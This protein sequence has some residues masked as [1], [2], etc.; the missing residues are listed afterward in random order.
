MSAS[1]SA[2]SYLRV[3]LARESIVA[4]FGSGLAN[5]TEGA[6]SIP[7]PLSLAGVSIKVRDNRGSERDAPLFYVSPTQVNYQIPE[8]VF[9][10]DATATV[11]RGGEAIS[12]ETINIADVAPGLFSADASGKGVAAGVALRVKTDSQG[13]EMI[14]TYDQTQNKF[15]AIPIDLGPESDQVFLSLFGTGW[16]FRSSEAAVKVTVGGVDVP[17]L[18]VGSQ[19]TFAGLDQLNVQLPRTLAGKG[20]VDLVMTVDGKVANTTRI[21]VK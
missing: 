14:A 6:T 19:P 7:L 21:N 16:R 5:T 4:M 1:V 8:G 9:A 2:A 3:G 12:V 17:V 13:Y 15:V 18:Y 11:S 10:G 20:E